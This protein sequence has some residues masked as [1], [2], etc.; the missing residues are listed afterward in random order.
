[1]DTITK[2]WI[3]RTNEYADRAEKDFSVLHEM[4]NSELAYLV[5]WNWGYSGVIMAEVT[6][7]AIKILTARGV[8]YNAL[9]EEIDQYMEENNYLLD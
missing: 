9:G 4:T 6:R 3:V 5:Y 2:E 7:E 8:D 1:M